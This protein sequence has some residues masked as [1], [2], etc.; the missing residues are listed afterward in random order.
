MLGYLSHVDTVL[1]S[2]EDWSRDPWSG[3]LH[4]G[5][6]WGRGALDMKSQTAAEVVAGAALAREGWRPPRGELK[7]MCVV[8]E[9]VGGLLGAQWLTQERPDLVRCDYAAQRGR[10]AGR[11]P[12]ATAACTAS[13]APRRARSASPCARAAAPATPRSPRSPTT[14][15]SSSLPLRRAPRRRRAR[16]LRPHRRA[17]RVPV[18]RSALDPADPDGALRAHRASVDD[19]A[20]RDGR[21]DARR[22]LRPDDH[23]ARRTKINVI[24]ARAELKVDCRVPPG[25][26][27]E[28]TMARVREVLGDADGVEVEFLEE[29][30]GNR[31]PLESPL[32]DAIRDWVGEAEPGAEVVPIVLPAFTDSRWFRDAFPDCVAYGFFPQRHMTPVRHLAAD[33]RRRRA[34]RRPRPRLRRELLPRAAEE[35]AGMTR[36]GRKLRLGGMAL[37]NGLLVHGPTHWAAAVRTRGGRGQGRVG[38]QAAAARRRRRAG[39]ARRRA[40]RRGDGG[41]PARQARAAGG[42]AA[43]PGRLRARRRGRRLGHRRAGAQARCAAWAASRSRRSSRSRRR[44]SRCAAASSPRT[45]ASSTRRSP[46]TSRAPR[47]RATPSKEHERCGSHLVAPMLASNLAGTLLLRRALEK[48]GPVAGGA[49]ALASTA[50][51]VEVF[52]WCERNARRGSRRRCGGRASRSSALIGTREPDERQLEVGRAALA[53]ILRVESA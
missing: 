11:S 49:V 6:V 39:R 36:T 42:A 3:E 47:T 22:D 32:M 21:A 8:D 29:V 19:A 27:A 14:R 44:C 23:R 53:E 51:A 50:V 34:D 10:R 25:M 4:D 45:T 20:R 40:A 30:I 2:P 17:A 18:A 41:D 43:V 5:Y 31:S 38:P 48:P 52:A 1:A 37:R 35:A 15:C 24:P 7:I 28:E 12:T 46:P 16:R 9:E 33:P 13:A 26:G